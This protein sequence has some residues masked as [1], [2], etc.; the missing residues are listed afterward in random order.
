MSNTCNNPS[1]ELLPP[2]LVKLDRNKKP[3]II[4]EN[5]IRKMSELVAER[6]EHT[7]GIRVGVKSSGCTGLA[8]T[9]EYVDEEIKSDEKI[10]EGKVVVYIDAKALLYLLG[11]TLDFVETDLECGFVFKNPNSKGSCG[12]GESFYV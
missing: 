5:A 9:F 8:Y 1:K 4:T 2:P 6:G 12:C 3:I 10:Q 7:L 11:T